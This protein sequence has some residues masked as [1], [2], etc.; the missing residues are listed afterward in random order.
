MINTTLLKKNNIPLLLTVACVLF[1]FIFAYNLARTDYLKLITLYSALFYL[2]YK[3]VQLLKTQLILLTWLAFVFRAIFILATPNLSQDFYRFIWDGRMILEGF[4]PYLHTVESFISI[5][6]FPVAQ[7][8]ALRNGMGELNASH[9]TNYPP[10]NQL[11]FT[12]AALFSGTSILGSVV[13]MRLV[14]IAADFGTLFFGKKLLE[15]LNMPV[16][17]IF[18]YVLNPFIIIE[19]TGNLHFEGVMI[20]FLVWSLYA[21]HTEKWLLAAIIFAL[22]ISTK[23]VPLLFL[24]LFFWWFLKRPLDCARGDKK[25][26]NEV[27]TALNLKAD[28]VLVKQDRYDKAKNMISNGMTHSTICEKIA[29][30]S[31][32]TRYDEKQVSVF[33]RLLKLIGFYIITLLTTAL[34]FLPFYSKQFATNYA[35]TVGLWFQDFEFNASLYYIA[36]EIGYVFRGY[37][38]IAFIGKAI[39]IIVILFVLGLTFLRKNNNTVKLITSM[40]FALSFYYFTAT[41][42]H[43]WYVATLLFLSVFTN[44]KFPLV[45]SFAIILSYLAYMNINNSEN[46]WVI[47]LEYTIVYSVCVWELFIKEDTAKKANSMF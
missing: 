41:T 23:L 19:L 24:P 26:N 16:H 47:G 40:L 11:C 14:I 10:I 3:L 12:I 36:R 28:V 9:F 2:F 45:W 31:L 8:Q 5:G 27:P 6:E 43:P 18:W 17:N 42:V 33:S 1:Y 21:L 46:F 7:A 32:T 25:E 13:V 35:K 44:Y 20:F 4:N 38:E 15:K 22:S 29:S 39:P 34:F 30:P 37:N